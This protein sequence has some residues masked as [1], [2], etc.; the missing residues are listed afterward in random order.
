MDL[1][2]VISH[3]VAR[4]AQSAITARPARR[5]ALGG[6]AALLLVQALGAQAAPSYYV[7]DL[8][9]LGYPNAYT[10]NDSGQ[11][12][13]FQAAGGGANVSLYNPLSGAS[14]SLGA[15]PSAGAGSSVYRPSKFNTSGSFTYST[16]P[17]AAALS[18]HA[19]LVSGGVRYEIGAGRPSDINDSGEVVGDIRVG[20]RWHGFVYSNGVTLDLGVIGSNTSST[21]VAINNQGQVLGASGSSVFIYDHGNTQIL[22]SFIEASGF[23]NNGDVVGRLTNGNAGLYRDGQYYDL[24]AL[25]TYF[26]VA[27]ATSINDAGYIVGHSRTDIPE[28][29]D[30][31]AFIYTPTDGM[32]D[33]NDLLVN[34]PA[35]YLSTAFT[36]NAQG[37]IIVQGG[38]S[39]YYLLTSEVPVPAAFWL[40]GSGIVGLFAANRRKRRL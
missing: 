35:T 31:H 13:S 16:A 32:L 40:F 39:H 2:N 33:L 14:Q 20:N 24:G 3:S 19:Y 6:V 38:N 27:F 29:S 5:Y 12:I 28:F 21:A 11:V 18:D 10:M 23:N 30:Y 17:S 8:T 7:T 25:G 4:N 15:V 34:P 36:I 26:N 22:S 1:R 37:Q 9:A